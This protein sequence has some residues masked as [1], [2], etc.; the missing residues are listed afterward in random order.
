MTAL[1]DLCE[2]R[3]DLEMA[4][5]LP[6]WREPSTAIGRQTQAL[7]RALR[8]RW[9]KAELAATSVRAVIAKHA[10]EVDAQRATNELLTAEIDRL[11]AEIDR[12]RALP[13]IATCGEC[14][15]CVADP[16]RHDPWCWHGAGASAEHAARQATKRDEP[17]PTWCPLRG[18]R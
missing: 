18:A 4:G 16:Q 9:V 12:L 8:D 10:A 7:A 6:A 14:G 15:H 1:R 13:V 17:P 3:D 2:L 5:S 11:T